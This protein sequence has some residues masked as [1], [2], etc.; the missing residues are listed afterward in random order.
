MTGNGPT[1]TTLVGLIC[2]RNTISTCKLKLCK[3][4]GRTYT[5]MRPVVVSLDM[6]KVR[7]RLERV[8]GPV[9][10]TEP[11]V[12]GWVSVPDRAD[13][14]LEVANVDWVE[15]DLNVETACQNTLQAVRKRERTMVTQSRM[16]AS[17]RRSPMM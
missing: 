3:A 13:V 15:A 14:A 8:V 9:K 1:G 16:S 11:L 7:T 2:P 5:S 12:D 4:V 17:V 6:L 10:L